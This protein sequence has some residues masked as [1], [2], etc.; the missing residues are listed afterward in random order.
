[1]TAPVSLWVP[2]RIE[3]LGKHTDY[4]GGRS[5]L[6]VVDRG[7]SLEARPRADRVVRITDTASGEVVTTALDASSSLPEGHWAIYPATVARRI[8]RNFPGPLI[9]ADLTFFSTLPQAAGMSS[10]SALVVAVFL[11]LSAVND[12]AERQEY[13]RNVRTIE[14]LAGYLG[15]IENGFDFGDLRGDVGVGT[16]SGCED[17]TAMLCS[18][19]DALVQ[20][21]F[22]PVRFERVVPLPAG[23]S[24]VIAVSGVRAEKT[25]GALAKYNR[26][27]RAARAAAEAWRRGAASDDATLGAALASGAHAAARIRQVLAHAE[28]DGFSPTELT[29]RFEQFAEESEFLV[30]GAA[31][32]LARGDLAGLGSLVDASQ[33][34]AESMLG[35]QIPETI[36]L[37]R[38][39]RE[40]GAVAASAFGAGFG[41][42]VWALTMEGESAAFL[43]F[44]RA[45]YL[46]DYP[47]HSG[48][49]DF[50]IT[51][52]GSPARRLS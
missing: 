50:F 40:L 47:M 10:S 3:L 19:A 32:A 25:A 34:G 27:S 43:E 2:G 11:A 38:S 7:I 44:W 29:T 26:I 39:A 23:S 18:R 9:G 13:V 6:C 36:A 48:S 17:Q 51:R 4:A 41:G 14:D 52:A 12:L 49:A 21:A 1:V 31:A 16:L 46:K 35:N 33:R 8:A 42:S 5:L 37:A 24:F 15:S 20:Y 28:A 45:R 22:C 30:P